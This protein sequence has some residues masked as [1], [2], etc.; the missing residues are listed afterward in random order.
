VP[1]QLISDD[2][3]LITVDG[4]LIIPAGEMTAEFIV[5][6]TAQ[7]GPFAPKTVGLT[8]RYAGTTLATTVQIVPPRLGSLVVTPNSIPAGAGATGTVTL[9]RASLAGEVVI[10]L[11]SASPGFA[12]V[13]PSVTIGQGQLTATFPITTPTIGIPF[14]TATAV[15]Q[16][17]YAGS[18]V[19]ARIT[20]TATVVAGIIASLTLQPATVTGGGT[21][22]GT[23]RLERAVPTDTVVGLAA[24]DAGSGHLPLPGQGSSTAT[25]PDSLTIRA[26]STSG[27]FVIRTTTVPRGTR[28]TVTIM[29]G[30]VTTKYAALTVTG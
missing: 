8:A 16:A 12:T 3:G 10:D 11:L 6:S 25:V 18:T 28:R 14:S 5:T 9:A 17:S 2:T 30:A 19:T 29:A 4:T 21:G 13:P 26:G 7:P 1:I 24:T 15:L 27:S 22:R 23:V 20:V